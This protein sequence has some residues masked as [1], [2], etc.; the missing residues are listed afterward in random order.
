MFHASPLG[1]EGS[2]RLAER[3]A[4]RGRRRGRASAP[5]IVPHWPPPLKIPSRMSAWSRRAADLR[6]PLRGS[7][8]VPLA[9]TTLAALALGVASGV[10][11][12][13]ERL[14]RTPAGCS[15]SSIGAF[16]LSAALES[17]GF[18]RR[19]ALWFVNLSWLRGRP[20]ALLFMFLIS[21]G[22]MSGLMSNTVVTVVWLSLATTIYSALK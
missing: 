13:D 22:M 1:P 9:V 19:F 18:N 16:G 11:T 8:P 10:L 14:P 7:S 2:R 17:N 21:A 12:L 20:Y 6:Y 15:G 3:L 4:E 5:S